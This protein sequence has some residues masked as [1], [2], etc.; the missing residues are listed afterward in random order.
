MSKD[1]VKRLRD[2]RSH[3]A[4]LNRTVVT[5][6]K[7]FR[8]EKDGIP[9]RRLPTRK[10][11]GISVSTSCTILMALA[12]N[13]QL[14]DFYGTPE[15][16]AKARQVFESVVNAPWTSAGLDE[17]NPFTRT[18]VLR[19]AGL[20]MHHNVLTPAA[21]ENL[22]HDS[23]SLTDIADALAVGVP[24]SLKIQ[25]YPPTTTLGYWF[26]DAIDR[27][28]F[29]LSPKVW[30]VVVAWASN[31][32]KEEL[33]F[34][35]AGQD[36][37]MD[38]VS[39]GMGACLAARL[40]AIVPKK[41]PTRSKVLLQLLPSKDQLEH[42]LSL[43]FEKQSSSGIWLKYFPLFYYPDAGVNYCFSFE[44]LEAL[45]SEF[46]SWEALEVEH[47]I[48][49]LQRAVDWCGGVNRFTRTQG[50]VTFSGWNS[51][52]ELKD[53][54]DRI[55]EAWATAV[56]HMFLRRLRGTLSA[57]INRHVLRLRASTDPT[58]PDKKKWTNLIDAPLRVQGTR[59][60]ILKLIE[61]HIIAPAQNTTKT[62]SQTDGLSKKQARSVLL[63]GPPGTSKTSIV[64]AV[65]DK[66]GWRLVE[67]NPSDFLRRGM[68]NI[69]KQTDQTFKDLSDLSK[70]VVFFDEMDAVAQ[71]RKAD[72]DVTRQ[73]LTTSMLPKIA[74]LH[75]DAKVLFFMATNH[76]SGL[77]EAITRPGRFDLLLF[78]GPPGWK[79]KLKRLAKILADVDVTQP[80]E[81]DEIRELFRLWVDPVTD[82]R[83]VR[84]LDL[85]TYGEFVSFLRRIRSQDNLLEA[86]R[87]MDQSDFHKQATDW[88]TNLIVLKEKDFHPVK[89]NLD[90]RAVD[91]DRKTP[92]DE[93]EED[94][95]K[96]K[97]QY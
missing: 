44:L 46:E 36:A 94:K 86:L 95:D 41:A 21:Q 2:L 22:K 70:A 81:I 4:E 56:V 14:E 87:K 66:L 85:F 61:E 88:A 19:T 25:H 93:Y 6:L 54:R 60:S 28:S 33:S 51:G 26:I 69:F 23:Q 49:H 18:L 58:R 92:R 5:D 47:I 84:L 82:R 34:V 11:D 76:I 15:A 3:A 64:R 75:D 1:L 72:L 50:G 30:E 10:P 20:L 27:L 65:A 45:L 62:N 68:D 74:S 53:L 89:P 96:S 7:P 16:A 90:L 48:E 12:M 57:M 32:F 79:D 52:T 37:M 77:D 39:M 13:G 29:K 38:P 78:V 31:T 71:K 83:I 8:Y 91:P 63:F 67:L 80:S 40:R 73:F 43:V 17:G 55:P 59:T 9:F 42:G 24:T 97:I 35:A